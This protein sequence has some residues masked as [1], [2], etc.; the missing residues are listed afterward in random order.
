M[1]TL[2]VFLLVVWFFQRVLPVRGLLGLGV[3]T[4][5]GAAFVF[6]PWLGFWIKS[7]AP[8]ASIP[9]AGLL[10]AAILGRA[11]NKSVFRPADWKA[12]WIFGAAASLVLYPSAL[13]LGAF[14]TYSLGWPWLFHS[15]S[16][17]LFAGVGVA[18]AL[19]LWF[20]NRFG[21]LL[22]LASL[23]YLAGFQESTNFWDYILDP[24]FGAVSL[25]A[26]IAMAWCSREPRPV[27]PRG[28]TAP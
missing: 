9:M 21:Y 20:G 28:T 10:L 15:V 16:I 12:A 23:G 2:T 5:A 14:D 8:N 17:A 13:G 27:N 25:V 4:A 24:L 19:L 26:L 3:S 1:S 11:S 7:L 22:L 18:S 6:I